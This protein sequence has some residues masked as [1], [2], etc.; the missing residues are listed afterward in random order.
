MAL[1]PKVGGKAP[2]AKPA[3]K[4]SAAPADEPMALVSAGP[5]ATA[6]LTV[7]LKRKLGNGDE[8]FIAP[9]IEV[10]CAPE[11]LDAKQAEVAERVKGWLDGLVADFPDPTDDADDS[12]EDEAGDEDGEAED[13]DEDEDGLTAEDIDGMDKKALIA[14]IKENELDVEGA[15]KMKLDDLREAVK[16]ACGMNDEDGEAEDDEAGDDD[17]DGDGEDGDDEG[18]YTE[19]ELKKMSLEDLQEV[20]NSWEIGDPVFKKGTKPDLKTKKAAY[21]KHILAAQDAGDEE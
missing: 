20:C 16:E 11:E 21:V 7:S 5:M 1:K 14:L 3:S 13:G 4:A 19:D 2:A 10:Q 8:V 17:E 15:S 9:G 6:K 18:G 12:T